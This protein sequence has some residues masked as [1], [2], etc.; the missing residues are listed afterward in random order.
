MLVSEEALM[1][2]FPEAKAHCKHCPLGDMNLMVENLLI[3]W[4]GICHRIRVAIFY[5][6][7]PRFLFL[8]I[9][10]RVSMSI[11]MNDKNVVYLQTCKTD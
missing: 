6:S 9:M 8:L 7:Q 5:L 10:S 1:M 2:N 11:C 4:H 3:A